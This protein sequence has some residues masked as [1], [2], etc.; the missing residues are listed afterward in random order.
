MIDAEGDLDERTRLAEEDERIDAGERGLAELGN[1]CFLPVARL[2]LGAKPMQFRLRVRRVVAPADEMERLGIFRHCNP[3]SGRGDSRAV[4][5]T[6]RKAYREVYAIKCSSIGSG[7]GDCRAPRVES[8]D[9]A[10]QRSRIAVSIVGRL[11]H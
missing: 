9:S 2:D 3:A 6:L 1:R 5:H 10:G 11:V 7:L 8:T 4:T